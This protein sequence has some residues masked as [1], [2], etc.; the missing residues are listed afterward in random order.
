MQL[1]LISYNKIVLMANNFVRFV[2]FFLQFILK[3]TTIIVQGGNLFDQP[4]HFIIRTITA[5]NL[6]QKSVFRK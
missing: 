5:F 1:I 2:L 3:S 6:A 4:E